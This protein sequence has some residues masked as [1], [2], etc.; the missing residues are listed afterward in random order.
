MSTE[1]TEI[2]PLEI[3][4]A[5]NDVKEEINKIALSGAQNLWRGMGLSSEEEEAH[6]VLQHRYTKIMGIAAV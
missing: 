6:S 3:S 2:T 4:K 1:Y 5:S